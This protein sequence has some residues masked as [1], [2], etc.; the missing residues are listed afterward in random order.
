LWTGRE[1]DRPKAICQFCDTDFWGMDGENGGKYKTAEL[2]AQKVKSLWIDPKLGKP[3]VVCTGGEPALQLDRALIDAF[4]HEGLEVAIETNG[5]IE[6]PEGIDW[7]CVSPKANTDIVVLRGD[8][9]KLVYPQTGLKLEQFEHLNFTHFYL[10]P[11]DNAFQK[12]NMRQTVEYCLA[13][14]QWKLS[15]QTHKILQIP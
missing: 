3:F 6:L 10:S 14:P 4:H 15:L 5:T 11:M 8:E 12:N 1:K 2:V 13:H 7:I 9:L